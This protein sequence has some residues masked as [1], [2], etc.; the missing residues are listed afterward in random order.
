MLTQDVKSHVS[1]SVL[2]HSMRV[3]IVLEGLPVPV[4]DI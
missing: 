4:K 1:L 2:W 3:F